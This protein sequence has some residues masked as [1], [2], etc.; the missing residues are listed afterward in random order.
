[1]SKGALSLHLTDAL[2]K[3]IVFAL[4]VSMALIHALPGQVEFATSALVQR[5]K[6]TARRET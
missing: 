2:Q 4:F 6:E 3:Q 5:N 1:M